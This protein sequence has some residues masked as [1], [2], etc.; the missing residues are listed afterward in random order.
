[1]AGFGVVNGALFLGTL[2]PY[3]T[4]ARMVIASMRFA[5]FGFQGTAFGLDFLNSGKSG[6][7]CVSIREK[8]QESK[9]FCSGSSYECSWTSIQH[10]LET[11][12]KIKAFI[13]EFFESKSSP[14]IYRPGKYKSTGSLRRRLLH[15]DYL[16]RLEAI[17]YY[18]IPEQLRQSFK[19]DFEERHKKW[20]DDISLESP[21]SDKVNKISALHPY[22]DN[23]YWL[24]YGMGGPIRT[25][26]DPH[27]HFFKKKVRTLEKNGFKH[28]HE[29]YILAIAYEQLQK[30]E[31]FEFKK[32]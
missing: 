30:A 20:F 23:D 8:Q 32:P 4:V 26:A 12:E 11:E 14:R 3:G 18:S 2:V 13:K 28:R 27:S 6:I 16:N 7:V 29:D 10:R 21:L 25:D 24:S 1:M 15:Y 31:A 22:A 9:N 17:A 19:N 5:A